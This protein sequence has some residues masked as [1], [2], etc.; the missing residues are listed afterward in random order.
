MGF[1]QTSL[2]LLALAVQA[3]AGSG[4]SSGAAREGSK[5]NLPMKL[6]TTAMALVLRWG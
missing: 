4:R 2:G 3:S 1:S 5:R 6:R